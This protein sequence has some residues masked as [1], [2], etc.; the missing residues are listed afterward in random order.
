M[1]Y[2]STEQFERTLT[3]TVDFVYILPCSQPAII[4]L[5]V[6]RIAPIFTRIFGKPKCNKLLIC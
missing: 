3:L 5:Y 2:D 6:L 4:Y 1:S